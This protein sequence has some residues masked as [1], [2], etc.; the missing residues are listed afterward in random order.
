MRKKEQ[1]IKFIA[2]GVLLRKSKWKEVAVKVLQNDSEIWMETILL[3]NL[4]MDFQFFWVKCEFKIF[5]KN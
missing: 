2:F 3:F 5:Y 4:I 1:E